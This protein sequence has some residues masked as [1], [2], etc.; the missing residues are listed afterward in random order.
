MHRAAC[1][2]PARSR[3]AGCVRPPRPSL[4]D[5]PTP[6]GAGAAPPAPSPPLPAPSVAPLPVSRPARAPAL[7]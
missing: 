2:G 6:P 1:H 7:G 5:A 3:Q 4:A